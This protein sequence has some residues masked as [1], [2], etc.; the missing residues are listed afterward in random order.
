MP[1]SYKK[2]SQMFRV[3]QQSLFSKRDNKATCGLIEMR[4]TFY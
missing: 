2:E 1:I 3:R 4:Q